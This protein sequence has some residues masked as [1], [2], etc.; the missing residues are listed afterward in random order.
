MYDALCLQETRTA[1]TTEERWLSSWSTCHLPCTTTCVIT[2]DHAELFSYLEHST[3]HTRAQI[4]RWLVSNSVAHYC[5]TTVP[6]TMSRQP[7]P[8]MH[9]DL[10]V[11]VSPVCIE[12][13]PDDLPLWPLATLRPSWNVTTRKM[14]NCIT[15][16]GD[17]DSWLQLISFT[18]DIQGVKVGLVILGE[19]TFSKRGSFVSTKCALP[20]T[21]FDH[22]VV[23]S[24][25]SSNGD[26][27]DIM[28]SVSQ[29]VGSSHGYP[30]CEHEDPL[31]QVVL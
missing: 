24:D 7:F 27:V 30:W 31:G 26:R 3:A 12:G 2:C 23:I 20:S 25:I 6:T 13:I 5:P 10:K 15:D 19:C 29:L 22:F 4:C 28:W 11:L 9:F 8:F 16:C 18:V 14:Q 21:W 17:L 1:V